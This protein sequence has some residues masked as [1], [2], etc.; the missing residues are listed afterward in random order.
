MP[1]ASCQWP[2]YY[3]S[4]MKLYFKVKK[5]S[6]YYVDYGVRFMTAELSDEYE[7]EYK[8]SFYREDYTD[9]SFHDFPGATFRTP[10]A[11]TKQTLKR[12]DNQIEKSS[13]AEFAA[14]ILGDKYGL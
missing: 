5:T 10:R 13:E 8:V 6:T 11:M 4:I 7:S 1:L 2:F 14:F 3:E 12:F 9:L